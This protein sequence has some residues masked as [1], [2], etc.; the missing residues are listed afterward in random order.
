MIYKPTLS[1]LVS[2]ALA[3]ITAGLLM[4]AAAHAQPLGLDRRVTE[5]RL[6]NGMRYLIRPTTTPGVDVRLVVNTGSLDE[7]DDELGYA[8]FVEHLAFRKTKRFNDGEIINFVRSLGGNFGQHLNAFTSHNQTQYWLYL[9]VG[10]TEALPTAIKI[11]SD[12][13]SGIEFVDNLTVIERGVIASEKRGRDQSDLPIDKV[14]KALYDQGLYQREIIGTYPTIQSATPERLSAFY[15]KH[16]TPERMTIVLTGQLDDGVNYW[17]R[18]LSDEFGAIPVSASPLKAVRPALETSPKIRVLQLENAQRNSLSLMSYSP[19][20]VPSTEQEL[21]KW[22]TRTLATAI[23]NQRLNEAAKAFPWALAQ[24]ASESSLT[25]TMRVFD[26][27]VYVSE[28]Q[29]FNDGQRLLLSTTE[30]FLRDGPDQDELNAFKAPMLQSARTGDIESD[31]ATPTALATGLAAYAHNGGFY[32]STARYL[33]VLEKIL[34]AISAKD[35]VTEISDR[36]VDGDFL[37]VA[38]AQRNSPKPN[39]DE[40]MLIAQAL[41]FAGSAKTLANGYSTTIVAQSDQAKSLLALTSPSA[42]GSVIKEESLAEGVSRWTLS[43]GAVV[44][45]RPVKTAVDQV[46]F[47]ANRTSGVW[48]LKEGDIPAARL[49]QAGAWMVDGIGPYDR[50][51]LSRTLAARNLNFSINIADTDIATSLGGRSD[52][53]E[54]G[55]HLMHEFFKKTKPNEALLKR[56]VA[57]V[58]PNLTAQNPTPEQRFSMAWLKD[59]RGSSPWLDPQ[60]QDGLQAVTSEQLSQ[61]H[62]QFF[63]DAASWVFAFTGNVSAR[64][65]RRLSETYLASLP[66]SGSPTSTN[67]QSPQ[68]ASIPPEKPSVTV[69]LKGAEAQRVRMQL[70]YFNPAIEEGLFEG[71]IAGQIQSVLSNRLRLSLRADTGL[72]YSPSAVAQT[73]SRPLQGAVIGVDLQIAPT[74]VERA[75]AAIRATVKSLIEQPPST[76]ELRA[77]AE[78]AR[79]ANEGM[80]INAGTVAALL[81]SLHRRGSDL[82][83]LRSIRA[84]ATR[85]DSVTMHENFKRWLTGVEP[86]VGILRPKD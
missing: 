4:S 67:Q 25:A 30:K 83:T 72:T 54:F 40:A 9:P 62:Q 28:Q 60:T 52:E 15:K 2:S 6:A 42:K 21:R 45:L 24:G 79:A 29:Y 69:D 82:Q 58:L 32:I 65:I 31:R 10:K 19:M 33:E 8:H 18:K 26:L 3:I 61:L 7:R 59:R 1:K 41:N 64:D 77:Y 70:R 76:E 13:A 20:S 23:L 35:I 5:G 34:P 78:G 50:T 11:V 56:L 84:A 51:A 14:R 22:L 66:G 73:L 46:V 71:T 57:Q 37:W 63:G 27:S 85:S 44:Y 39:L 81:T 55:L 12:W 36:F 53:L 17:E 47:L 48:A 16:Y 80:L 75:E 68:W 74:D 43:N 38:Q 86:S 49:A